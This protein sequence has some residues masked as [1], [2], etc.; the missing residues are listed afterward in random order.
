MM[1]TRSFPAVGPVT[2]MTLQPCCSQSELH[3]RNVVLL[4]QTLV[5]LCFLCG[6]FP[7]CTS[8]LPPPRLP[9]ESHI[10]LSPPARS[11]VLYFSSALMVN[12]V[13]RCCVLTGLPLNCCLF[14]CNYSRWW[15]PLPCGVTLCLLA[16]TAHQASLFLCGTAHL[17]WSVVLSRGLHFS[18]DV[19]AVFIR[20]YYLER[21]CQFPRQI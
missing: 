7:F 1:K 11:S 20:V 8:L 6:L 4:L 19:P 21:A 3:F 12:S 9:A 17:R 2:I 5:K 15:A 16:G 14:L 18:G 13:D 10:S